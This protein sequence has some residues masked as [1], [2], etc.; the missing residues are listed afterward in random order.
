MLANLVLFA[1]RLGF[2]DHTAI[3]FESLQI[4]INGNNLGVNQPNL[5]NK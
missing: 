3:I 1:Q 5:F 2:S 4:Y